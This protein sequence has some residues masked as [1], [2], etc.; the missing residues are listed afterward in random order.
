MAIL[1]SKWVLFVGI[2]VIVLLV[3]FLIGK[4]SVHAEIIINDSPENVWKVLMAKE[5]YP[6]W[7]TVLVPVKGNLVVGEAVEYEFT[8]DENT[9]SIIPS[10]VRKILENKLLN[11]GGGMFGVL[12]FDHKYILENVDAG[13]KVTV[14][15]DYR[16]I[17]VP[18]WNPEPVQKAYERLCKDLKNRVEEL[19]VQ[20]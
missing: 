10:N 17:A 7:N 13:T 14:H 4:K 6:E 9:K 5:S 19:G 8:Q 3:L 1:K 11:Q 16:G 20:P 18:F 15:E 2:P 12:T